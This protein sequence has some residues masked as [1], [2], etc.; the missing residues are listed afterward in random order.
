MAVFVGNLPFNITEAALR[1]F[2]QE[3]GPIS[4]VRWGE[5]GAPALC[6]FRAA[7]FLSRFALSFD[8]LIEECPRARMA[9]G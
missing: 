7:R 3:C 6:C 9:H 4:S 5:Q 8:R 1:A 2:L